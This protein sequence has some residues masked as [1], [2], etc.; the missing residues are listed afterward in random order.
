[1]RDQEAARAE[2]DRIKATREQL[3]QET[4]IRS[5]GLGIASLTGISRRRGLTSLLGSG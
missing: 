5:Q 2:A 1:M 4:L 3:Q